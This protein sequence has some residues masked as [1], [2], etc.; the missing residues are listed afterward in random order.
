[1]NLLFL[2]LTIAVA[3][4][5]ALWVIPRIRAIAGFGGRVE[6]CNIG[7]GRHVDGH[8]SYTADADHSERY[9]VVKR[10]ATATSTAIC[11]AADIPIGVSFD[12]PLA[13]DL[14]RVTTWSAPGTRLLVASAAIAQDALLE[15]AANGR[16]A[17]AATTT[18]THWIVGRALTPAT[19]AG[20]L[21]EVDVF[22]FKQVL[23]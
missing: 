1:M 11:G 7:E 12:A 18:G 4:V 17:T 10:G 5:F 3:A 14:H 15:P 21:I 9:S 19:A 22:H 20:Q 13:G 16:V 8:I 23:P 6:A 2:T